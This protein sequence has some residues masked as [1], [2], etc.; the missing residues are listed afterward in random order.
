MTR[1]I[2]VLF[3]TLMLAGCTPLMVQQAGRPPLGFQGPRLDTDSVTSFDGTRLG[4]MRWEAKGEPWAVVVGLHGMNDYANAFHLAAPWWAEQGITTL[5]Y[6]QRGFGRSPGRG[7]WAGDELMDEDLRTVVSL[8]RRA[9]PHAI[10]VVVGESMG[11][12]VAAETFA[13]DRPPAADRV[14]LLSPAVWGWREQPLPY[15]TLLWFAANFT[16]SKVYTPPRWLTR[17]VSPTDNRE[18]LIAMGRDP[19]MVWG[20][21]SDTLYGLVGMM[22]RAA[23]AVGRIG[24]PVLYLYGAHDQI[25]PK[26]AALRAVKT[27]KPT[28]R[29]AYYAKGWHLM[30]RDH[31]GPAVWADIAAFI[32]DPA[33]PLPSGAPPIRG[34]PAPGG[35]LHVA[36]GL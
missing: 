28:D 36:A 8:A 33:A 35:P 15:R 18:E 29:T 3:A 21:R 19:L 12:A 5:A 25:I 24:A 13:S 4:L 27:L 34:A 10:I 2:A 32:R 6:D 20:A 26:K 7:V 30:M 17:K 11:G 16:A 14:V 23:D 1:L 22:D 31:Q 9:Y